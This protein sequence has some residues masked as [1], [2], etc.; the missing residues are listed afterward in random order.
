[1]SHYGDYI[2]ERLGKLI[3]ESDKGFATYFFI[4]HPKHGSVVYIEDIYVVPEFR[5]SRAGTELADF[6]V[7]VAKG[8]GIKVLLGSINPLANGSTESMKALIWYG[9]KLDCIHN[10]LI[11]L[12]KDLEA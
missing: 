1:M 12:Y 5:R 2:K 3:I 6:V 10:D 4:E 7:D 8:R 9:M 11:Y